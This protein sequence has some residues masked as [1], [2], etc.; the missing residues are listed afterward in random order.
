MF[1]DM[2]GYTALGQR[3]EALSLALLDEHRKVVRPI[4]ARHG[5]REVKT[6]GD[7]FLVE[8]ANVLD[9]VRCAYDIQRAVREFNLSLAPDKRIHL[10]IGVHVGDV[11]E[12]QGDIAGDS[13]NVASRVEALAEDGGVC[14][15]RQVHDQVRNKLELQLKGM[16]AK[17]LKNVESPV[18][19][20]RVVMPWEERREPPEELDGKRIGVLPFTNISPGSEDEYLAD[21][22]TEELITSLSGVRELTV[23]GRTSVMRYKGATKSLSEIGGELRAGSLIEGSVRRAGDRLRITVQLI[24]SK[25]EGHI[26]AQN[27]DRRLEDIFAIQSEIAERVT[28]ELKVRLVKSEKARIE[29]PPTQSTEAYTLYLKGRHYWN[30]RSREGLNNAVEYFNRS[31]AIDPRFALG[32]S[33][34]ADCYLVMGFNGLADAIPSFERAKEFST[35]ALELDPNLGEAHAVLGASIHNLE[36]EWEK[37]DAEMRRSIE[38]NPNYPTAH[39]WY[40]QLLWFRRRFH[41]SE[42]EIR[43][44]VE[45]DP[46]SLVINTNLGDLLYFDGKF[47]SAIEQFRKV[48]SMDPTFYPPHSSLVPA[49]VRVGLYEEALREGRIVGELTNSP[50]TGKLAAAYVYASMGKGGEARPLLGEAEANY[51]SEHIT[52]YAI[53]LVHFQLGDREKGFEWLERAY[54]QRDSGLN[55]LAI[56]HEL[57]A[58]RGDP[59]YLAWVDR[60]GLPRPGASA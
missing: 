40:S 50:L 28:K 46:F 41:E 53:S 18:E 54:E 26:W 32:H 4:L 15:T 36:Y 55:G 12:S 6:I 38:L 43:R 25:S 7:A 27:Y 14:I 59:R 22:M 47:Q 5:G 34:L 2:V 10:R 16:G 24:N 44:A 23:I 1:T 48:V 31:L 30:E 37:S 29:T 58:L 51:R 56:D 45:L 21:G 20:Y 60:L 13:V 42:V 33:A 17:Q 49:Y 9:A 11:V 3:N 57:E 39:Q 8:F 35:R 52:P 19:V